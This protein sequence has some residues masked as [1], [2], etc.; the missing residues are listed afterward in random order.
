MQSPNSPFVIGSKHIVETADLSQCGGPA[1]V[2]PP[3]TLHTRQLWAREP[4]PVASPDPPSPALPS[5][6]A[7]SSLIFAWLLA[8]LLLSALVGLTFVTLFKRSAEAVVNAVVI[9]QV[10][11][12]SGPL[13]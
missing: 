4:L 11:G 10:G 7:L 8:A 13:G 6:A 12:R 2:V 5:G 3:H 9:S 1:P